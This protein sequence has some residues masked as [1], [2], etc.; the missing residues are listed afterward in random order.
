MKHVNDYFRVSV[1]E[2]LTYLGFKPKV[3]TS[4][5]KLHGSVPES[6]HALCVSHFVGFY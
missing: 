6:G 5:Q 2:N 4:D 1:Y 3:E